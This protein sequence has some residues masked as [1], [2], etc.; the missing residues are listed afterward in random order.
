MVKEYRAIVVGEI[1]IPQQQEDQHSSSD[2]ANFSMH[3]PPSFTI[4]S[5]VDGRASE[6]KVVV[7]GQTPCPVNGILTDLKLFPRTGRKHQLRIHC[8]EV[9]G[10]PILGDDLY[11]DHRG[12]GSQDNKN[13]DNDS[14]DALEVESDRIPD[15]SVRRRQGLYLYCKKI[16]INHP[17]TDEVVSAEIPEP[18]RFTR[19]RRKALK[20][21]KWAEDKARLLEKG[22]KKLVWDVLAS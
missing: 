15:V 5:D 8:A 9:L 14:N 6:T 20:G 21:F 10:T 7:L 16:A 17:I 4:K 3:P 11:W 18:F 13:S 19:T 12:G 22:G 2:T 1:K